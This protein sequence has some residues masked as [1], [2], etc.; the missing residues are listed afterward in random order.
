MSRLRLRGLGVE[1]GGATVVDA[2][3]L[4]C[5]A[6]SV[7]GLLGPNGS[8]KSTVLR[9][10][11]RALRPT[12]GAVLVDDEDVL[13]DLDA[14]AHARLVAAMTQD[15]GPGFDFTVLEVV[16]TGRVPHQ[17]SLARE[18]R[19]DRDLVAGALA[20]VGMAALAGRSF[21]EL[22]GGEKQRVLLARALVQQPRVLVLD[23]PTNHLD[24]ATQLAL[25]ELVR[26]LGVTV[27]A[28]LHDLNLAATYCDAV[29]LL[30]D[31]VVVASG[32]PDDVLTEERIA[33]VFG[34]AAHRSRHPTTGRLH[35]SFSPLP[36]PFHPGVPL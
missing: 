7:V 29:H 6:G 35:L 2:L 28:A 24:V 32:T 3:D 14:R 22:S 25:L 36:S 1:L 15:Q 34:V 10:V 26:G 5:P 8:G 27:L 11:Y 17:S 9:T 30:H 12:S 18:S 21:A 20:R 4:D 33:A 31:G 19:T 16:S 13:S 23:E